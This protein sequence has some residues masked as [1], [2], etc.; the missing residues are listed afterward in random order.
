MSTAR[1][2]L[3]G[4]LE[5][6]FEPLVLAASLWGA[7]LLEEGRVGPQHVLLALLV[8]ALIFPGEARLS[9]PRGRVVLDILFGWLA[10]AGLLFAF[11]Y[12]SG[13]LG[14]FRA[15]T[16]VTWAW[17]APWCQLGAH[18]LLRAA[19]PR[20]RQLE[21]G[22]KR[23]VIA[24]MNQ[25]GVEL[26]GRLETNLY[27][28]V[29]VIGFVDDRVARSGTRGR[30][31]VLGRIE[32]LPALVQQ[33]RID[34]VYLALPM[35]T[36]PRTVALLDALRDTTASVYFVP[37]LFVTD[38][39]QGR[40]D[41]ISG[42]PV[43]GVCDSPFFGVSALV[44]RA[45]DIVLATLLL[46]F[47]APLLVLLALLVRLSSRGPAIFRQRRCGL[48]GEEIT[49]YKFRT[50]TVTEDGER[51]RQ[52]SRDDPRVTRLGSLMRRFSLDELPQLVNV[53]QGRMSLV[54]P[55]PHAVAHNEL[56]RKLIKGYMRRHKVRPGLSGW[57]QVNGLRGETDTLDKMH[58]R[59]EYDLDY[60]RNWSLRLD[61]YIMLKTVWVVLRAK[62]A[63]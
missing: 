45:S 24:G 32:A 26:A 54:G 39:I 46:A 22:G 36:Q 56:Y 12:A 30:Y 8:F 5:M 19:A 48:D 49:V 34:L 37:D 40:I 35:A 60:L 21:R 61:L 58:A 50:M 31:P 7:A 1:G 13:Y 44:K 52:A 3:L 28:S 11:G 23:A 63:Y 16:L 33:H 6:A 4:L 47:F 27:S 25:P 9:L 55:R 29:R 43:L 2:R 59:I 20:L 57:A 38:L 10:L 14:Y 51:I 62:H 42:M 17:A 15:D 41:S 18:L 53:L